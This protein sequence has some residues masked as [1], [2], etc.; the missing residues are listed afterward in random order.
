MVPKTINAIIEY[1]KKFMHRPDGRIDPGGLTPR[2]LSTTVA[3]AATANLPPT[4]NTQ[5][6][7][8]RIPRPARQTLNPGLTAVNSEC[9]PH[10]NS[11][12]ITTN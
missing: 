5:N 4:N 8:A 3:P 12:L 6:I 1:Q 9:Q 10:L 11:T 2:K 7:T